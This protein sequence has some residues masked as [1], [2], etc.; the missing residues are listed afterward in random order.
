MQYMTEFE[1]YHPGAFLL[2]ETL[3]PSLIFTDLPAGQEQVGE[4]VGPAV[5]ILPAQLPAVGGIGGGCFDQV[6]IPPGNGLVPLL[7]GAQLHQ[8]AFA[9]VEPCILFQKVRN[10]HIIH[11]VSCVLGNKKSPA[12]L[13]RGQEI[14]VVPPQFTPCGASW[15]P[16]RSAGC[17]GPY[18]SSPTK[19]FSEATPKGIP[20]PNIPLP[21]TNRQLSGGKGIAYLFPSM[22]LY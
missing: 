20:H 11:L 18:P 22:C 12:Y 3:S 16:N 2:L 4:S 8:G 9:A 5:K 21:R 1:K 10:D 6:K 15:D 7:R 14:P 17:T 13:S 19:N